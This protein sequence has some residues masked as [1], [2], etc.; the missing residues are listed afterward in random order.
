MPL[1]QDPYDA[2]TYPAFPFPNTHPDRL[3]VMATLHGLTSAPVERCRVL[4]I[5]C[6]EGA[7]LIPMA[8][9]MPQ[10]QFIGFDLA[11]A[12]VARAQE[13]IAALGLTNIRIFAGDL[14]DV[15]SELGQFDYIIAHGLYS[16]VPEPVRDRLLSLCSELLQPQGVAFISYN[17]LPGGHIRRM[18]REMMQFRVE[19]I[20]D[21]AQ[22]EAEATRFLHLVASTRPENDVYRVLL[23]SQLQRIDSRQPNVTFHD[24]LNS[25][26]DTLS[27]FN[28]V[29][30]AQKHGLQYLDD[31]ELPPPPDPSYRQDLRP[32]IESAAGNDFLRQEQV[33]DFF[34]MRQYRETL[35][36]KANVTVN[37]EFAPEQFRKLLFASQAAG[38]KNEETGAPVFQ[39]P[40]G[41]KMESNHPVVIALLTALERVWPRAL[42]FDEL[43]QPLSESGF[44]LDTA[45]AGLLM[46][47]AISKMIELRKWRAP[48]AEGIS[49]RPRASLCSRFEG[50][51]RPQSTTLLHLSI[52]LDDPK[53]KAFLQFADGTRTRS[54][55]LNAMVAEFPGTPVSQLEEGIEPTLRMFYAAGVLEA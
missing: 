24:E 18:L 46:R 5:A 48:L 7:N 4:E 16:W 25:T 47:L 34:R 21:P 35:L 20:E 3:A 50:R 14:L 54:E 8:Y 40:G 37:R 15:G 27:F 55:L 44:V 49:E 36:C 29:K 10:S 45:G 23:E 43:V 33:L 22:R 12:P 51:S 9:A 13:R 42:S 2:F 53:I 41:I 30:H 31:A 1:P 32:M 26:Y 17:A 38:T 19:D 52:K 39:L 28:F 6:N 11:Q